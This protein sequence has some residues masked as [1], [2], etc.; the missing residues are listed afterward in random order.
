[1][2]MLLT[3]WLIYIFLGIAMS[4]GKQ[5]HKYRALQSSKEITRFIIAA[6]FLLLIQLYNKYNIAILIRAKL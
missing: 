4:A 2:V 1:M 6:A 5:Q 3:D